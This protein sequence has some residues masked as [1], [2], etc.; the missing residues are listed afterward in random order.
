MRRTAIVETG[1]IG[2][3]LPPIPR[4][5][6]DLPDG[7]TVLSLDRPP[8][9]QL[10]AL[11]RAG[12]RERRLRPVHLRFDGRAKGVEV[13]PGGDEH[14]RRREPPLR[15]R[16]GRPVADGRGAEFDISVYDI[17]GLYSAGG[18]AIAVTPG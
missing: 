8:A 3:A 6:D 9:G 18:A 2:V 16:A 11:G 17:F 7:V 13:P 14:H 15:R 5:A 1:G 10:A 4:T 12:P